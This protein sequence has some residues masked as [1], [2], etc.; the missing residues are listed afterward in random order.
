MAIGNNLSAR[1]AKAAISMIPIVFVN[2]ADPVQLGLVASIGRPGANIT[3]VTVLAADLVPKRM[4]FLHYVVPAAKVF[5]FLSI[6]TMLV[7]IRPMRAMSSNWR[8][9]QFALGEKT[10]RG[11][12]SRRDRWE[13]GHI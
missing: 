5:G 11:S 6:R 2:G 3:G 10:V 12:E 4:Q 1:A 9:L 13:S 7:P 8:R